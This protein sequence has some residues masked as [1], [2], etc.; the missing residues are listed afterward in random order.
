MQTS[1]SQGYS[2]NRECAV[3]ENLMVTGK[4]LGSMKCLQIPS[5][6][7]LV[8]RIVKIPVRKKGIKWF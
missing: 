1:S 7:A 6:I 2:E 5:Y 8:E 4:E 3:R